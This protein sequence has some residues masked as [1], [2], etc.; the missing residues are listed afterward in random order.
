M[1][2]EEVS[3]S[4]AGVVESVGWKVVVEISVVVVVV[5]VVDVVVGV[6]DVVGAV[7]VVVEVVV[8]GSFLITLSKVALEDICSPC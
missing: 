3:S 7:V 4:E 1:V 5:V 2:V 8:K 6:V